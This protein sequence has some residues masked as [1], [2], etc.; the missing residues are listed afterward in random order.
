MNITE[1]DKKC[2]ELQKLKH[3]KYLVIHYMCAKALRP[4]IYPIKK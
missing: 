2:K 4:N 1:Y 3:I